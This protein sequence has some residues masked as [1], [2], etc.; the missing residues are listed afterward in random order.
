MIRFALIFLLLFAATRTPAQ[1]HL[2]D[3]LPFTPGESLTYSVFY[4]LN[5]I[6]VAAGEVTFSVSEETLDGQPTYHF[7]GAGG[8]LKKYDWIFK[9]RDHYQSNVNTTTLLPYQFSRHVKH[10]PAFLYRQYAFDYHKKE[11]YSITSANKKNKATT[12]DTIPFTD[13][14]FDVLS[15]IYYCRS[16]NFNAFEQGSSIPLKLLLDNEVFNTYVRYEGKDV[17]KTKSGEFNCIKFK[18]ALIEGTIFKG[19]E[20]MVVW[21]TDDENKLPIYIES[22]ILVG[23]IRVYLKDAEGLKVTPKKN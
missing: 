17:F 3:D 5:N 20:H 7:V 22:D 2:G 13:C 16:L 10:Q 9:V 18:P 23:A 6:W 14:T 12:L 1:C 4:H 21:V 15:A 19:G 8:T 11:A